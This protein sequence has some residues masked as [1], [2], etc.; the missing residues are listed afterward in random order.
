MSERMRRV[1]LIHLIGIGGAGMGGIAEVLMNLGYA[2]QGS[3]LRANAV[4]ARLAKM[5]IRIFIGHAAGQV[6]LHVWFHSLVFGV[7]DDDEGT[8]EGDRVFVVDELAKPV[9]AILD[10][11]LDL[12]TLPGVVALVGRDVKSRAT[13]TEDLPGAFGFCT[14]D[15]FEIQIVL[16]LKKEGCVRA[17]D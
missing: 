3:D 13:L 9:K 10:Q 1:S 14:E 8:K 11:A 6:A 4:T 16:R 7:V 12:V 5:G 15:I 2:V 17:A